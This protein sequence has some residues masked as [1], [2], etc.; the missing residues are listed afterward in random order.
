MPLDQ[1]RRAQEY[2]EVGGE[3]IQTS[4]QAS[5]SASLRKLDYD[6]DCRQSDEASQVRSASL[7]RKTSAAVSPTVLKDDTFQQQENLNRKRSYP[8]RVMARSRS[9]ARQSAQQEPDAV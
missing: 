7:R 9:G 2:R 1:Y 5:L 8:L 3:F 4:K 6:K